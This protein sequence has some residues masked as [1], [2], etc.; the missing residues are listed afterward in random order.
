[1]AGRAI[2]IT[3]RIVFI[4]CGLVSLFTGVPYVILRGAE[5]PVQSEWVIFVVA[6]AFVGLFSVAVALLQSLPFGFEASLAPSR[7]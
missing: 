7:F 2:R 1:M 4:I 6:L 5:L 3:S